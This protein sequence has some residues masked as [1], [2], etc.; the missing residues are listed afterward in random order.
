MP[1][2]NQHDDLDRGRFSLSDGRVRPWQ[3]SQVVTRSP[4]MVHDG[5]GTS[6]LIRTLQGRVHMSVRVAIIGA[7]N[8]GADHARLFAEELP[9]VTLTAIC[10]TSEARAQDLVNRLSVGTVFTDPFEAATTDVVDAVVIASPDETHAALTIAALRAGKHVLCEKP[11]SPS[12]AECIDVMRAEERVGVQR[13]QVGFMRRFD[14]A[15]V[16]MKATLDR[17]TI[18][19]PLLM[20]CFHRNVDAPASFVR[21]LAITGSAPHEFDAAR[22]LLDDEVVSVS[23]FQPQLQPPTKHPMPVFMVLETAAGRLVNV[24]VNNHATYGYDVR[25]ELVGELGSVSLRAPVDSEL[26]AGF[27]ASSSYPG[28]W[29]PRFARAYHVQNKAWIDSILSGQPTPGAAS[30]WDGYCA[31]RI[32]EAGVTSMRNGSAVRVDLMEQPALYR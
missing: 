11:L 20:H 25:A 7:G 17:G 28:D 1:L 30:A 14:P 12:S 6:R 18:G 10:D 16:E 19:A 5:V 23:V 24:E 8:M 27:H 32:A 22:W 21:E 31:A 3:R 2:V 26:H 4:P 29:R 15:Y 13:V 9:N